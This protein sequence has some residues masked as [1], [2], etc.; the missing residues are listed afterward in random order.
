MDT[1]RE[2]EIFIERSVEK[3]QEKRYD[4]ISIRKKIFRLLKN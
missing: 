4:C 1:F 3:E 2:I